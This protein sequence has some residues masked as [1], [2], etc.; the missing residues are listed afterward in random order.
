[1]L[2]GLILLLNVAMCL[3]GLTTVVR[4][5]PLFYCLCQFVGNMSMI[6]YTVCRVEVKWEWS[7]ISVSRLQP[8]AYLCV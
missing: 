6:L 4:V 3:L 5:N 2:M 8:S 1:M 7:V